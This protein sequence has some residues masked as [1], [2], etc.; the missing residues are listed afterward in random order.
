MRFLNRRKIFTQ[1]FFRQTK[2]NKY[3][4]I[5]YSHGTLKNQRYT[6]I[7]TF[8]KYN[9]SIMIE[10]C[11][12]YHIKGTFIG[13]KIPSNVSKYIFENENDLKIKGEGIKIPP[14]IIKYIA[15]NLIFLHP[16]VKIL[17]LSSLIGI[18]IIMI[19]GGTNYIITTIHNIFIN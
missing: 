1:D 5:T 11:K 19:I 18:N 14:Y 9:A 2:M 10:L 6:N 16:L 8:K 12:D 15:N 7:F 4:L 13:I 3:K 17:K